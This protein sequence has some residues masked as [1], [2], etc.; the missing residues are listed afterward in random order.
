MT[1]RLH[2]FPAILPGESL[3]SV[4]ACYHLWSGN[5]AATHSNMELVGRRLVPGTIDLPNFL[6]PLAARLPP[7]LGITAEWMAL[8]A[9]QVR[10]LTAFLPQERAKQVLCKLI[11]GNATLHTALGVNAS[12]VSRPSNL[13]FCADCLKGMTASAG[14]LWWRLDHQLPGVLVCPDHGT[15]LRRCPVPLQDVGRFEFVPATA[16]TCPADAEPLIE[17]PPPKVLTQ[18]HD[19]ACRSSALLRTQPAFTSYVELTAYYRSRLLDADMMIS[20]KQLDVTKFMNAFKGRLGSTLK[21]LE[22]VFGK[23][24]SPDAWI[25][26]MARKHTQAKHPLQ[27]VIFQMFLDGCPLRVPPFGNGPWTCP[28]PVAAHGA[29]APSIA[30]VRERREGHGI[31]GTFECVCGYTYT[32]SRADDGRLM[33]PRYKCFGP[34][35]DPALTELVRGGAT[36]R[37]AAASL[38]IHP[39]AIAAAAERLGL[40]KGWKVPLDAGQK[41]GR[42]VVEPP[43]ERRVANPQVSRRPSQPRVDWAQVDADTLIAVNS[44]VADLRRASPAVQISLRE[45]ERRHKTVSWI[46]LRRPKL[47]L[48][49]AYIHSQIETTE[50]F[51][52]R[53]LRDVI[54]RE[55]AAGAFLVPS[56]IV[57]KASLK[58]EVW[59]ERARKI[60]SEKVQAAT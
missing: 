22:G 57:R 44:I 50:Q 11:S 25:L 30:T 39:R 3:Y 49:V 9:T 4:L 16:R 33:G 45:I 13:Q 12:V 6:E 24:A 5:D 52:E 1:R 29:G 38:G 31:V 56:S 23:M 17:N 7:D 2:T 35:L 46:Y 58:S 60:I 53:R 36:L 32:M 54:E 34:L 43:K 19:I 47:P 41:L 51:Q 55:L 27:H 14:R 26:E 48:T 15:I 28:N 10:Y 59:M 40:G 20:A 18:L 42:A 8:E 21:V 37:G